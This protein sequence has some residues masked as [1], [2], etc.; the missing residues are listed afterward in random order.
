MFVWV[1][2]HINSSPCGVLKKMSDALELEALCFLTWVLE[3]EPVQEQCMF[4]VLSHF[5][6]PIYFMPVYIGHKINVKKIN[7]TRR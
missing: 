5:S 2:P 1:Y 6:S 7:D 4:L 3:V